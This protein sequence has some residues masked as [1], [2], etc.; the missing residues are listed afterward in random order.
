MPTYVRHFFVGPIAAYLNEINVTLNI[1]LKC[2]FNDILCARVGAI[3]VD[4]KK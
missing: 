2:A 1:F 4:I 3:Q